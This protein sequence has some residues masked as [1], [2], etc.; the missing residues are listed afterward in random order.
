M[1]APLTTQFCTCSGAPLLQYGFVVYLT[2]SSREHPLL[3]E[4]HAVEL[5]PR[6]DV[7]FAEDFVQVVLHRARTDEELSADLGI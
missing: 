3:A 5:A 1:P 7:Q 6:A 4:L 2:G